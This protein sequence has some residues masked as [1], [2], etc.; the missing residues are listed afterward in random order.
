MAHRLERFG[1]LSLSS[2]ATFLRLIHPQVPSTEVASI[3]SLD[4]CVCCRGI[5]H[6]DESEATRTPAVPVLDDVDVR[7]HSV[8][9]EHFPELVFRRGEGEVSHVDSLSQISHP[10][11]DAD[12][13]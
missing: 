11:S 7:D 3:E 8:L 2:A 6:F 12:G 4:C 10:V 5:R 1:R 13:I 9:T